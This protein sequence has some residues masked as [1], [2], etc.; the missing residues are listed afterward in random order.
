MFSKMQNIPSLLI[1]QYQV[2]ALLLEIRAGSIKY[3]L[4]WNDFDIGVELEPGDIRFKGT[5]HERKLK[6][7]YG[8]FRGYVGED[9]EALDAYLHPDLLKDEPGGTDLVFEVNQLRP[10]DGVKREEWKTDEYKYMIGYDSQDSADA[11]YLSEMPSKF[12]GG[13]KKVSLK[14]LEKYKRKPVVA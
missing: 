11:A 8:H 3:V 10:E 2:S 9:G 5:D 12:F 14:Y 1:F 7:G 4:K 6:N 13:S